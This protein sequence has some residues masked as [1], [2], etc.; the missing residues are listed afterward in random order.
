MARH[1]VLPARVLAAS[2][3]ALVSRI[4]RT[5]ILNEMSRDYVR[6]AQAKGL[7]ESRALVRHALRN[8]LLPVV[9]V[10]GSRIGFLFSGAVLVETVFGWPGL[11]RYQRLP[12]L[13][14]RGY[15]SQ[16]GAEKTLLAEMIVLI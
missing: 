15:S 7:S 13:S 16:A 4:A 11:G 14:L 9:T 10:V 5:G 2:E 3:V 1:L 12:I 6:T 8:A